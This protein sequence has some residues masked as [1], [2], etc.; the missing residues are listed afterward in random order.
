[1][2]VKWTTSPANIHKDGGSCTASCRP[3]HL[4]CLL[5]SMALRVCHFGGNFSRRASV[6]IATL[7]SCPHI[8]TLP[9]SPSPLHVM[10]VQCR[11]YRQA[12][13]THFGMNIAERLLGQVDKWGQIVAR[14]TG[15]ETMAQRGVAT[16]ETKLT[17][18]SVGNT[19]PQIHQLPFLEKL[20]SSCVC[21]PL[22]CDP[23]FFYENIVAA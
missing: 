3:L 21:L 17:D 10:A 1:M 6:H 20:R 12:S 15:R 23:H 11:L 9:R 7:N 5:L 16:K 2:Q 13:P 18:N 22:W 14:D 8:H 4:V 19:V